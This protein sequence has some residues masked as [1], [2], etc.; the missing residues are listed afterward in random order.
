MEK[1]QRKMEV[2][3]GCGYGKMG[4]ER[5]E[6]GGRRNLRWTAAD[7]AVL[8]R[9]WMVPVVRQLWW[10]TVLHAAGAHLWEMEGNA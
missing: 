9:R 10:G 3:G 2:A 1:K 5:E 6:G 4:N 7:A 8:G